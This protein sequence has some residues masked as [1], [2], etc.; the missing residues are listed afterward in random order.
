M[1]AGGD[2][3]VVMATVLRAIR[4]RGAGGPAKR[5]DIRK[6]QDFSD[7]ENGIGPLGAIAA[8][9]SGAHMSRANKQNVSNF[10]NSP[11]FICMI[12]CILKTL[13]IRMKQIQTYTLD[14]NFELLDDGKFECYRKSR[15][16]SLSSR[17]RSFHET[18]IR[19]GLV[20]DKI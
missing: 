13:K 19:M 1:E 17:K 6:C 14:V 12:L 20:I 4:L 2:K 5:M 11:P 7:S 9:L 10:L 15:S 8:G 18:L 3:E 16:Y